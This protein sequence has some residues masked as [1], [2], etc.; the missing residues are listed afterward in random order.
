MYIR[1]TC[2]HSCLNHFFISSFSLNF[3]HFFIS[4][5]SLNFLGQERTPAYKRVCI[6]VSVYR[7]TYLHPFISESRV[8]PEYTC[9]YNQV[10]INVSVGIHRQDTR[11]HTHIHTHIPTYK[12]Q[13]PKRTQKSPPPLHPQRILTRQ[14]LLHQNQTQLKRMCLSSM[15]RL[16]SPRLCVRDIR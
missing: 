7:C 11:I 12:Q 1:H 8:K 14:T 13:R 15:I 6:N 5:F 9:Y 3:F 2:T 16:S 4:S 10:C